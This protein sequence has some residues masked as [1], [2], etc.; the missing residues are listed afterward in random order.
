MIPME[1]CPYVG[2]RGKVETCDA[3]IGFFALHKS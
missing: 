1:G 2:W 3:Q